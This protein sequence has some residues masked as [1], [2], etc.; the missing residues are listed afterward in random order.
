METQ[1]SFIRADRA[2]ELYPI[3]DIYLYISLIVDPRNTEHVDTLGF[4]DAL[5]DL[6]F[7]KLGMLV[8][9]ILDR[10]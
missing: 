10:D 1:T 9:D 3:T 8:V 6:C 7:F 5:N 2:V 4:Y